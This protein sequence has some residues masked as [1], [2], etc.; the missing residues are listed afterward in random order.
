MMSDHGPMKTD[1]GTAADG[2]IRFAGE[3]SRAKIYEDKKQNK[4]LVRLLTVLAY[5]FSVSLAAI[6]LSLYYVFLWN[7][8]MQRTN[9]T[10]SP[11]VT[12]QVSPASMPITALPPA[13]NM[14]PYAE[15]GKNKRYFRN[16]RRAS[17]IF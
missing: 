11:Q 4:K 7:P 6:V 3:T 10:E 2:D 14:I 16:G 13:Q 12:T 8:N 5:V 17:I 15:M 9:T 1:P